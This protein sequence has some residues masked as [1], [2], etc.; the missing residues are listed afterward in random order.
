MEGWV[1][2]VGEVGERMGDGREGREDRGV[3]EKEERMGD[4]RDGR[5][6]GGWE[7]RERG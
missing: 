7:R 3:G 5:E 4:G 2:E 6:D 1:R